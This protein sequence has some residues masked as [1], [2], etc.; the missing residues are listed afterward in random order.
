MGL[1]GSIFFDVDLVA[2]AKAVGG[3]GCGSWLC[4]SMGMDD[5]L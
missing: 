4:L 3:Y 5:L 1:V 2:M